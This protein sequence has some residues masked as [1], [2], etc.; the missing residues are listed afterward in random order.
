[1]D[2]PEAVFSLAKSSGSALVRLGDIE[3]FT[4]CEL[5]ARMNSLLL[6]YLAPIVME[7]DMTG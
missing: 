2:K 4:A 6:A 1:M 7:L 3:F 5:N